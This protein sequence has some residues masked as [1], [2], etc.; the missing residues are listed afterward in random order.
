MS[1]ETLLKKIADCN[2][3]EFE[4]I[5]EAMLEKEQREGWDVISKLA[6]RSLLD[7]SID[8]IDEIINKI[9]DVRFSLIK[10]R[11]KPKRKRTQ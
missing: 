9:D 6:Q 2:E 3:M 10:C 7:E 11:Y 4:I 5:C 8:K 1:M